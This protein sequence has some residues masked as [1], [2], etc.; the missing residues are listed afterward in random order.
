MPGPIKNLTEATQTLNSFATDLLQYKIA[1]GDDRVLKFVQ[2]KIEETIEGIRPGGLLIKTDQ[3]ARSTLDA[4]KSGLA[5]AM[6][7]LAEKLPEYGTG[8][9][10][11][12]STKAEKYRSALIDVKYM[13]NE[14]L[15]FERGFKAP[16]RINY[17]DQPVTEKSIDSVVEFLDNL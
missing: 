16:P 9:Q 3:D 8:I 10:G 12:S 15:A 13:L 6:G 17:S 7:V 2:E 1:S 14:V 4:M 5:K 11:L